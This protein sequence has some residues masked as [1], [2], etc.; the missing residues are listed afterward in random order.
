VDVAC[1]YVVAAEGAGSPI[2]KMIRCCDG[3]GGRNAEAYQC[4]LLQQRPWP[5]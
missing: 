5:D 1:Q 3:R 2:R 4:S